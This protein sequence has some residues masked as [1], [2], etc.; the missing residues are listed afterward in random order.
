LAQ[1]AKSG[2]QR[3]KGWWESL[4]GGERKQGGLRKA[5]KVIYPECGLTTNAEGAI[6]LEDQD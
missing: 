5:S 3:M 1:A 4:T 6:Q 2:W